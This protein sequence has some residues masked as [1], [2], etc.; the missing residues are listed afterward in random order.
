MAKK[1]VRGRER[2]KPKKDAKK[3]STV[4]PIVTSPV[5]EV[6]RKR[7]PEREPEE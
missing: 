6:V 1:N 5:V 3:T 4:S 7:K 2:R